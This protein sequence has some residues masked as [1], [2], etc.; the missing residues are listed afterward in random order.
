MFGKIVIKVW[1]IRFTKHVL[2]PGRALEGLQIK[3][4]NANGGVGRLRWGKFLGVTFSRKKPAVEQL[5]FVSPE[6][7]KTKAAPRPSCTPINPN[8]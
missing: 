8:R 7:D 6:I 4:P 5:V 3:V 1:G 2:D